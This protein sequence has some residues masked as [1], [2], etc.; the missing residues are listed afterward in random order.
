MLVPS[1][2]A[3]QESQ[4]LSLCK[5]HMAGSMGTPKGKYG[6]VS[7][8]PSLLPGTEP[9][10]RGGR[11]FSLLGLEKPKQR[12]YTLPGQTWAPC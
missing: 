8:R 4:V 1:P 12:S 5:G 10:A 7:P 9:W 11:R 3:L 6:N 2:L